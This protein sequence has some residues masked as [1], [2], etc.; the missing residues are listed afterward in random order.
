M[1]FTPFNEPRRLKDTSHRRRSGKILREVTITP[2]CVGGKRRRSFEMN[3]IC[4]CRHPPV[5]SAIQRKQKVV[6][7][8]PLTKR[9][10][11]ATS[12]EPYPA[13][14]PRDENQ[15]QHPCPSGTP[16]MVT[17]TARSAIDG[18]GYNS[19]GCN[20]RL[21]EV[22]S[23]SFGV[24]LGPLWAPNRVQIDHKRPRPDLWQPQVAAA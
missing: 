7:K 18:C 24:D 12:A 21:S 11:S 4:T 16:R 1:K 9:M 19:R 13:C 17:T 22:R 3:R 10:R 15:R 5:N 2:V 6:Q 8:L 14:W 20:L 23:G